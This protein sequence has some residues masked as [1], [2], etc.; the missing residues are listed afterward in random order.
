M[1]ND[2][3]PPF[4]PPSVYPLP[5]PSPPFLHHPGERGGAETLEVAG[6]CPTGEQ[7]P[8]SVHCIDTAT[9]RAN[10]ARTRQTNRLTG[11]NCREGYERT[12]TWSE[13]SWLAHSRLRY[14]GAGSSMNVIIRGFRFCLYKHITYT[15]HPTTDLHK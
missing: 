7:D 15:H 8:A 10:V 1:I 12:G 4:S 13:I 6:P 3:P 5:P 2:P 9:I 14:P 11:K